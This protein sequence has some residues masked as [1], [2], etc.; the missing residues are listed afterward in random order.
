M[1]TTH[2]T[3]CA[4]VLMAGAIIA[5][6]AFA[7]S[8][9]G[10]DPAADLVKQGQGLMRE[11]QHAEAL[12]LFQKALAASPGS[13]QANTQ[14]GVAL[15]L[16]GRYD[17]A[18]TY[19]VKAVDAA[20][21]LQTKTRALRNMAMSYAFESDCA[22]AV[23]YASQAVDLFKAENDFFNQGEVANELARV[24]LESGD[25]GAAYTWYQTG[26]QMGLKEPDLTEARKDLWEFR[27]QH[28]Q[29]RIAARRGNAAEART[30]V[31]AAK[32][33]LDKGTN[34]DQEVYFPY[35]T[36]YVAFYGG[37][38]KT[39]LADLMKGN[40]NDPFIQCLIAQSHEKLGDQAQA[41]AW[42]EKVLTSSAH[43]PTTAYARPIATKKLGTR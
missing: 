24:C 31:A 22:G 41:K 20:G 30:H 27:W 12:A 35:L 16:M 25:A 32:A 23:K 42:Y 10:Q 21:D 37:D 26:H 13:Y 11:G 9:A 4:A 29:A 18:R 14:A 1:K 38:Y 5:G 40:Q 17:E 36:G 6:A 34:P 8:P 43:N 33:A 28:A 3:T 39:A 7:A 2:R 19:L 15:D